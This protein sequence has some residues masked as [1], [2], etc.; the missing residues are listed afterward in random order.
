MITFNHC[1]HICASDVYEF[2]KKI[3]EKC[4]EREISNNWDNLTS[5]KW[6]QYAVERARD[7]HYAVM[8]GGFERISVGDKIGKGDREGVSYSHI[9]S[10]IGNNPDLQYLIAPDTRVPNY[11][12]TLGDA[13]TL[14]SAIG[15]RAL[16][17]E[18]LT[19]YTSGWRSVQELTN[20]IIL[21]CDVFLEGKKI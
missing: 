4:K 5:Q 20:Q 19:S 2:Y 13:L 16:N 1:G 7:C 14:V 11:V 15:L 10:G 12:T 9:Y 17:V 3:S 18:N 21:A 8:L 6:L